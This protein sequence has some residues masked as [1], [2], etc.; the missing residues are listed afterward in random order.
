MIDFH[1]HVIP[2][3]DDGPSETQES[4]SMLQSA[5]DQGIKEVVQTV[6][7]QHPKMFDKNVDYAYLKKIVDDSTTHELQ[8]TSDTSAHFFKVELTI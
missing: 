7:F 5:Q 4:I 6:H 1:N 8:E 3:V 2:N